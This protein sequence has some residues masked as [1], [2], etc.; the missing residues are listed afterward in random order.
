MDPKEV[1]AERRAIR[2]TLYAPL[3]RPLKVTRKKVTVPLGETKRVL[4]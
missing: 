3:A 1:V 2:N 4:D